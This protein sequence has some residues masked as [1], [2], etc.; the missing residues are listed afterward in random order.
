MGFQPANNRPT[1]RDELLARA[2]RH[3]LEAAAEYEGATAPNPP[4][5]CVLLDIDGNEIAVAAHRKAGELHAEAAAI[6]LAHQAGVV[7]RIHTLIVTLEPCNHTGRTPPCTEAIMKT[8]AREVW[9]GVKDHNSSVVGHGTEKLRA[10]GLT[11]RF[12]DELAHP[13]APMLE[14]A[15]KRLIAPFAKVSRYGLPW[16]TIKQ[17]LTGLGS[18]IPP[19]GQKT[20]TSPSSLVLAHRLRKRADAI[21][22]GS[23]TILA[24]LPEF[25]VRH[26]TDFPGKRRELII[27]DRRG[28]V[29]STYLDAA[30]RRGF[31]VVI[32]QSL[33]AALQ[34]L[35]TAGALEVLLEAGPTLT[36]AV[37][38]T[39]LWNEHYLIQQADAAGGDDRVIVRRQ[40]PPIPPLS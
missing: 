35:G 29:P 9:I 6:A 26:V 13:D 39:G 27:L 23:G 12:W 24:D 10:A 11:V 25:T 32:E 33:D 38:A 28:R 36:G 20:F 18:M 5:G 40:S 16:L 22:T 2:F 21:V 7:E 15:A 14:A 30:A 3:A 1:A 8:P 31:E 34:R 4:V 37:L 17:A 19:A